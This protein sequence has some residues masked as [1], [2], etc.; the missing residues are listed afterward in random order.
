MPKVNLTVNDD[1]GQITN[2]GAVDITASSYTLTSSSTGYGYIGFRFVNVDVPQGATI[3]AARFRFYENDTTSSTTGTWQISAEDTD[4][5]AVFTTT[6]SSI[7]GRSR[8]ANAATAHATDDTP[9][10]MY[11]EADVTDILQTVINRAGWV[12]GNSISL[13]VHTPGT[14]TV[15]EFATVES[16]NSSQLSIT[17]GGKYASY[18]PSAAEN[19]DASWS[20]ISNVYGSQNSRALG[21]DVSNNS[22]FTVKDF[23]IVVDSADVIDDI[24]VWVD[25]LNSSNTADSRLNVELSWDGGS[26]WTTAFTSFQLQTS[27]NMFKIGAGPTDWGGHVFTPSELSNANFR[28]RVSP[29]N[30]TATADMQVDAVYVKVTSTAKINAITDD[31]DDGAIDTSIWSAGGTITESGGRLATTSTGWLD[32]TWDYDLIDSEVSVEFDESA[33]DGFSYILFAGARDGAPFVAWYRAT[34]TVRAYIYDG[35][36]FATQGTSFTYNSSTHR[37]F[38]IRETSGTLYWEWSTD[39]A[40]WTVHASVSTA[41]LPAG[42]DLAATKISISGN[43]ITTG[44][45][46][47]DNFNILPVSLDVSVNVSD[48][49]TVSESRSI[50]P[51]EIS[52]SKSESVTVSESVQRALAHL[53]SVSDSVSVYDD[54]GQN[55]VFNGGFESAPAFT[56]ATTTAQRWIDGSAAGSTVDDQYRWAFRSGTGSASAQFDS[57]ESN[58]GSQSLKIATTATGSYIEIANYRTGGNPSVAEAAAYLVRVLPNTSYTL[59]Y[60]M[61]TNVTSGDSNNGATLNI[62]QHSL[63]A[64]SGLTGANPGYVKTTTGWTKYTLKFTTHADAAYIVVDPRIYGHSGAGTL[65]MQ[66]W[67]DDIVIRPTSPN[68]QVESYVNKSDSVTVTE[69][70]AREATRSANISDTATV[71]ESVSVSLGAG[72]TLSVSVSDSV[73]VSESRSLLIPEFKISKSESVTVTESRSVFIPEFKVSKSE[74]ITVSES[75]VA[76]VPELKVSKSDSV[77]VSES[78]SVSLGAASFVSVSV[79]DTVSVSESRSVLVPELKVSKSENVTVTESRSVLIPELKVSKSE[80]VT[81]SESA[82]VAVGGASSVSIN[83]SD[84]VTVSESRSAQVSVEVNKSENVTVTESRTVL[85]PELKRSVSD[86]ATVTESVRVDIPVSINKSESVT[87]TDTPNVAKALQVSVSDSVTVTESRSANTEFNVNVS[88]DVDVTDTPTVSRDS[89]LVGAPGPRTESRSTAP[90]RPDM[91]NRDRIPRI[92][93][94]R[95]SDSPRM[96]M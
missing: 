65:I 66:A 96:K 46:A 19:V 23:N 90:R 32:T 67:F 4:N 17:Y 29:Q 22:P 89:A 53:V 41:S 16:G 68:V 52:I 8:T 62:T 94:R 3:R 28:V 20:N 81:V 39:G 11:M 69:S 5:S 86:T 1:A 72:P 54:A 80:S 56:A 75:L 44:T 35:A 33:G 83:V 55:R 60:Y 30:A 87:V 61:K 34:T 71:S 13:I 74:S 64:G 82:S 50:T 95:S 6:A 21:T 63:S 40:S 59:E 10:G 57:S 43:N 88:E 45:S 77:T 73:T 27:D 48:S 37:Y 70:V 78:V 25:A 49:V 84:S 26:S 47:W 9:S 58:S 14:L 31:F 24:E 12:A 38:R 79:S 2:T 18:D 15:V 7:S 51:P 76:L 42:W 93:M 85:I 36:T 92:S 91:A